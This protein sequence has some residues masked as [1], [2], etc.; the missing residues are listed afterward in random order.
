MAKNK[1]AQDK[2][3]CDFCKWERLQDDGDVEPDMST[4]PGH[5][6]GDPVT[7]TGNQQWYDPSGGYGYVHGVY[8]YPNQTAVYGTPG[9]GHPQLNPPQSVAH[10]CR[11]LP[12]SVRTSNPKV[13][14][15]PVLFTHS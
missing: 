8:G 14:T 3:M 13:S 9:Y 11:C 12:V 15:D 5:M 2:L 1:L 10:P 7:P 6:P 4:T